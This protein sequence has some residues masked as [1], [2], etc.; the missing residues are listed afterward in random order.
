MSHREGEQFVPPVVIFS[1]FNDFVLK[2]ATIPNAYLNVIGAKEKDETQLVTMLERAIFVG[3]DWLGLSGKLTNK[4][5]Q[6]SRPLLDGRVD[7]ILASETTYTSES[8]KD[9]AFLMLAHLKIDVGVGLIATKR[10]YFGVGGGADS[11]ESAA[12]LLSSSSSGPFAGLELEV[13][14]LR[15]YD[16]GTANIRDMIRVRCLRR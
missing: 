10:F 12:K 4:T 11:F 7:L 1:D 3:G 5:L 15:Q 6:T 16:T 13:K 8:C 2:D 14:L 9:T